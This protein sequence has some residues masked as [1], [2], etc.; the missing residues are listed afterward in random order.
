MPEHGPEFQRTTRTMRY[1]EPVGPDRSWLETRPNECK[2][3]TFKTK[4]TVKTIG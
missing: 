3:S 4:K 1:V 2:A